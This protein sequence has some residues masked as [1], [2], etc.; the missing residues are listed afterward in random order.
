MRLLAVARAERERSGG[1]VMSF[2][3]AVAVALLML[4]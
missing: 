3:F 1:L 4:R 2:V